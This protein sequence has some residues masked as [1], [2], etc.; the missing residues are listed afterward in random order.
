MKP[1]PDAHPPIALS[2][3]ETAWLALAR[4]VAED[5]PDRSRKTGAVV[6]RP[7]GQVLSIGC[8]TLTEG[9]EPTDEV[10]SRPAKYDWT[11]HA[12]RNALF[13]AARAGGHGTAGCTMVVP[14]FPCVQCARAVAQS[15]ITRLVSPYPDLADPDWGAEFRTS[16]RILEKAGVRFDHFL[17]DRPAPRRVAEGETVVAP[18][19]EA[20]RLPVAAW[21][22]HW[23]AHGMLPTPSPG[24]RRGPRP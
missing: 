23:N 22:E 8:N 6:V 15:G 5:S 14:W 9:V 7:D 24:R 20:D 10:L 16:L 18:A 17:D 4:R 12:E 2:A 13:A 11:E 21:V 3:D 1:F 19:P